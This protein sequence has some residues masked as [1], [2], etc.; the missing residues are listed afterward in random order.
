MSAN[1]VEICDSFGIL[2]FLCFA[3]EE[4]NGNS[5]HHINGLVRMKFL[6][7]SNDTIHTATC[8]LAH[9]TMFHEYKLQLVL[10]GHSQCRH[11]DFSTKLKLP[12]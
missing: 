6:A 7:F 1:L 2:G 12:G 8:T 3:S 9:G 11:M 5:K 10:Y 4:N